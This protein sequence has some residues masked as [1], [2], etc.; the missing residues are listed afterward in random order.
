[1][2]ERRRLT[3]QV[4]PVIPA[5]AHLRIVGHWPSVSQQAGILQPNSYRRQ[6]D[7][8]QGQPNFAQGITPRTST[9]CLSVVKAPGLPEGINQHIRQLSVGGAKK[10]TVGEKGSNWSITA[11]GSIWCGL[12]SEK[13]SCELR[14]PPIYLQEFFRGFA[15]RFVNI[16]EPGF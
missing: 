16:G 7:F 6:L 8:S 1:M 5:G 3:G 9:P 15:G 14:V 2:T 10:L 4:V 11:S 13:V 12:Y